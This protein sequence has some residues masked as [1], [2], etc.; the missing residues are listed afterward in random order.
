MYTWFQKVKIVRPNFRP[1]QRII[2]ISDIH[3]NLD[4]FQH[5][6]KKIRFC[7]EDVLIIVGDFL[8]KG[9]RS[10]DTLHFIMDL[11]KQGNTYVLEGNCDSWH[12]IFDHMDEDDPMMVRW[13]G[14]MAIKR[15]GLMYEMYQKLG[16][17]VTKEENV[18]S[19]LPQVR[20]MYQE[21]I[22]FLRDIPTILETDHYLFVHGGVSPYVPLEDQRQGEVMKMD[23]FRGK[24]WSFNKWIIVGHWPV[25]L[26]VYDHCSAHPIIDWDRKI[27]SIDGGCVLKDDGQLNAL[28][29]P[30]EGSEDFQIQWYDTFPV[31]RAK[32]VQAA[33]ASSYYIR[34]G[35]SEVEL[36]ERGEEFSRCR[37]VRTGYEMDILTKYLFEKEGKLYTNDCSDYELEIAEGDEVSIIEETSRG[38]YVKHNGV[39]GWYYGEVEDP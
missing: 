34:W 17:D 3:A 28:I 38:F 29:I 37:H 35:D 31:R 32:G 25:T 33:S 36:L 39:S 13:R 4:Y 19:A 5:L 11:V 7:E 22:Q 15:S 12:D 21:E 24:G 6:L 16:V 26:Y 9:E 1:N 14:Y 23:N 10:L 30:G 20:E 8:E 27:I 2:A 18:V